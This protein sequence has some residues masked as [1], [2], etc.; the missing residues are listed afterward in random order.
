MRFL[1]DAI[2][3]LLQQLRNRIVELERNSECSV[4]VPQPVY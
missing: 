2:A 3:T 1:V 4:P